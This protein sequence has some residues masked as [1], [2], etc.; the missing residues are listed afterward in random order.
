VLYLFTEFV[1]YAWPLPHCYNV[2]W[3]Q[4]DFGPPA[5]A[6]SQQS[7]ARLVGQLAVGNPK[8]PKASDRPSS[9][10]DAETSTQN[11]ETM[12]TL[13]GDEKIAALPLQERENP[14]SQQ[15]SIPAEPPSEETSSP[16]GPALPPSGGI[17]AWLQ[18]LGAFFLFFNSW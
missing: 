12:A 1:G 13:D 4:A 7:A 18:V 3:T 14:A 8:G 10:D 2:S 16:P 15:S 6:P 17:K 11:N 9:I 5:T